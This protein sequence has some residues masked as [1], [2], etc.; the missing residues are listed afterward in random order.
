MSVSPQHYACPI[1][2]HIHLQLLLIRLVVTNHEWV[3]KNSRSHHLQTHLLF[4][5]QTHAGVKGS[6]Y[7][8]NVSAH[9]DHQRHMTCCISE[10]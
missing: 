2:S 7:Y 6:M 1:N 5:W 10:L 3:L 8:S 9:S 4:W